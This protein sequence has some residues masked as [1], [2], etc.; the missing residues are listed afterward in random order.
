MDPFS[1][2]KDA[3]AGFAALMSE[4]SDDQWDNPSCGD[5]P[6]SELVRHVIAGDAMAVDL[7]GGA[8]SED[9]LEVLTGT[10]LDDDPM[11]QFTSTAHTMLG[12]F[13]E[14]GNMERIVHHPMGDMPAAQVLGFRVGEAALHGWDLAR[15][16]D[17]DDTLD[18]GVV[19]SV[20]DAMAPA[21][22]MLGSLGI[23]GA[24]PSGTIAEDAPLQVRL[25][26][27]SGRRL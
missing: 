25:L 22:D 21:K 11:S 27:L 4:I 7:V 17:A 9:A 8:S 18:P 2:L 15:A 3:S 26:D 14:P 5:W 6:V 24:G 16:I 19:Q 13:R 1:T 10:D 20:W 23:F 12:V